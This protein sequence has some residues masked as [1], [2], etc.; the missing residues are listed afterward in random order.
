MPVLEEKTPV[1]TELQTDTG[2]SAN[3]TAAHDTGLYQSFLELPVPVVL[4]SFWLVGAALVGLCALT[5][6]HILWVLLGALAAL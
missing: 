1:Q 6:Y 3:H 4:L 2:L 5:L